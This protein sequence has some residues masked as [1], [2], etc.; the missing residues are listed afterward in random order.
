[1]LQFIIV[2]SAIF[3]R[4]KNLHIG[5]GVLLILLHD[6][7]RVAEDVAVVNLIY[8]GRFWVTARKNLTALV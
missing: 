2:P 5:T 3:A 8:G 7:R 1:L 4:T 6:T